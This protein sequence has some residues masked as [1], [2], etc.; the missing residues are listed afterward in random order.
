MF[1][2][3]FLQFPVLFFARKSK[4]KTLE[5]GL[6]RPLLPSS[7][8][9][10]R[11]RTQ[12]EGVWKFSSA[13]ASLWKRARRESL[14]GGRRRRRGGGGGGGGGDREGVSVDILDMLRVSFL[15]PVW[16]KLCWVYFFFLFFFS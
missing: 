6:E 7:L 4:K 11:K 15:F 5:R 8:S 9:G 16:E 10:S 14:G 12:P 13:T 1:L 3:V 2:N